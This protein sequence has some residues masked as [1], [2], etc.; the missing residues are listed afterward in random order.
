MKKFLF[1]VGIV[2]IAGGVFVGG[3]VVGTQHDF[4]NT[5]FQVSSLD[6]ALV[7]ATKVFYGLS[8]LDDGDSLGAAGWLN[9]E[10][11]S[12]IITIGQFVEDCPNPETQGHARKLLARI[13]NH[14]QK[15]SS[16]ID[17]AKVVPGYLEVEK[18]VQAVLDDALKHEE[19]QNQ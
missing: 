5:M 10:L 4:M 18:Q 15:H 19:K 11:N 13:A 16:Q 1:I 9:Q 17:V 7:D 12:H 3:M 8:K 6:Q 2:A 14:R